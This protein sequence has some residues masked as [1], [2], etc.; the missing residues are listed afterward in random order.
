MKAFYGETIYER[1][2][3]KL[4]SLFQPSLNFCHIHQLKAGDGPDADNPLITLT[5]A[6]SGGVNKLQIRFMTPITGITTELSQ[7]DL[8]PYLGIWVEAFEKV[9]F[10]DTA[11]YYSMTLKK[12]SNDSTML[13]YS[14]ST[15]NLWR[16]TSTFMRP[17]WGFYRSL[18]S[19]S[20]L[21]D[22]I[23]K[24]ADFSLIKRTTVTL[25]QAPS[26]LSTSNL[27]SNIVKLTW[28]DNSTNE[29]QFRID[30]SVDGIVWSY[31]ACTSANVKTYNDTVTT[32]GTNYYRVRAENTGGNSTFSNT[33][34]GSITLPVELT[35]F[36]ASVDGGK[37]KLN[38]VTAT[39]LNNYG[40]E[41]ERSNDNN[42]S[43]NTWKSIAFIK[44]TGTSNTIKTYSYID[45]PIGGT[46][47]SYRIKQSDLS[48]GFRYYNT[49]TAKISS[50]EEYS[51]DQN[52]PNPFNPG[53]TIRYQIPETGRVKL[54]LYSILGEEVSVLINEV[55]DAGNYE[56]NFNAGNLRQSSGVY[57][58]T[59]EVYSFD[60]TLSFRNTR[61]MIYMK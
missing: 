39:E 31:L 28:I 9:K 27:A 47:F 49:I 50:P 37:V 33:A 11:S 16:D 36:T 25:P 15:L 1:W 60:G 19:I 57:F 22:E 14:T 46:S 55:K 59:L 41:I 48:G 35:S 18:S 20:Y 7:V 45:S 23:I 44:G 30:R 51:L 24:F 56:V 42:N 40:F 26:V 52:Y 12:V 6:I 13:T 2:K 21:R 32:N 10:S 53:T 29:D 17:K 58:Y 8:Q 5:P 54:I 61:K 4:D 3:F 34:S 43:S 38:W